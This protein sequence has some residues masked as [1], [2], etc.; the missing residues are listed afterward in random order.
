MLGDLSATA[1]AGFISERRLHRRAAAAIRGYD[2]N[3]RR[4]GMN[5]SSLSGGNQQKL[6]LARWRHRKVRVLLADEPTRGIDIG[7]KEEILR[8]LRSLADQGLAI[9]FVSSELE[10]VAAVS[11]RIVVLSAGREAGN[12]NAGA[13]VS[14]ILSAAFSLEAA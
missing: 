11:D 6:L 9:V 14:D 4:L 7:A 8:N 12:L 1:I 5:A 10:E 13:S 2:F 3:L